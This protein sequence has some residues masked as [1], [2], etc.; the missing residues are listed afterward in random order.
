MLLLIIGLVV[1]FLPHSVPIAVPEW[2]ERAMLRLGRWQWRAVHSIFS[3]VGLV[4][5]VYGFGLARQQ[6]VVCYVPPAW[7][8]HVTFLLMLPV[9]PLLLAGLMP[10]RIQTVLK[11]PALVAIKLWAFAH[12]LSNGMLADVVLFGTFLLWAVADRIALRRHPRTQ[13]RGLPPSRYNDA[14]AV[15]AGL[16]LYGLFFYRLHLWLIGRNLMTLG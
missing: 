2:N 7:M 11:H 8:H 6:P 14:I 10:G 1:F 4:L 13:A 5:I 12:L 16:V 3:L 15:A 9:F